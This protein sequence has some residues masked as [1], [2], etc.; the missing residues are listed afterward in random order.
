LFDACG[1]SCHWP[2]HRESGRLI[3]QHQARGADQGP[4]S[5]DLPA[6]FEKTR[7]AQSLAYSSRGVVR[8]HR[9]QGVGGTGQLSMGAATAGICY[10]G[11]GSLSLRTAPVRRLPQNASR[12][13]ILP[14]RAPEHQWTIN[15]RCRSEP[16]GLP[17][18]EPSL[19]ARARRVAIKL[20]T[21]L[22]RAGNRPH[23]TSERAGARLT[24]QS[25]SDDNLIHRIQPNIHGLAVVAA[26]ASQAGQL[27][28]CDP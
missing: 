27:I 17:P 21:S 2:I 14:S 16:S 1:A 5:L 12:S 8:R 13:G 28:T 24:N 22:D 19:P 7:D 10:G 3:S 25:A 18:A 26:S 9:G 15:S 11:G 20:Q 4:E 6:R 23:L